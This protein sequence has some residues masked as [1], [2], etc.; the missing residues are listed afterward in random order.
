MIG[1]HNYFAQKFCPM[2]Q[3]LQLFQINNIGKYFI[4][5]NRLDLIF[6]IDEIIIKVKDNKI[7]VQLSNPTS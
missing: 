5:K 1:H 6:N 2:K 3:N 7:Q 4:E